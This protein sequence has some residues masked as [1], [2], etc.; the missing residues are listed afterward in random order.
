MLES[1]FDAELADLAFS[2]AV[3]ERSQPMASQEGMYTIIEVLDHGEQ[4]L[5]Q[6]VLDQLGQEAFQEWMEAQQALAERG[7]YR[8]RVPTDP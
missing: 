2:M 7:T 6:Y 3:G 4:E 5:D 8:D 1:R